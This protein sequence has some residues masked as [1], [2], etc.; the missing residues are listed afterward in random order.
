MAI[1]MKR[2]PNNPILGPDRT[3]PW[4]AQA[5]F[6]G[7]PVRDENGYHLLYRALAQPTTDDKTGVT[8]AQSTIGY[9]FSPNG[10]CFDGERRQLIAPQE[11]AEKTRDLYRFAVKVEPGKPAKLSV[12]EEQVVQETLALSNLDDGAIVYFSNQK[13]V[14]PEVKA[15][16]LDVIKRKQ[17]LQQVVQQSQ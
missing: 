8:F 14:S 5:V 11:P 16:L 3:Q 13:T 1:T 4:E 7:C 10:Y 12:I 2:Y 9:A 15:A 6:N 17:S